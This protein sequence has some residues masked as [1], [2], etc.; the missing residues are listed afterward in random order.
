MTK[1]SLAVTDQVISLEEHGLKR[2]PIDI[3]SHHY[4]LYRQLAP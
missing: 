1:S 4:H 3:A 2:I